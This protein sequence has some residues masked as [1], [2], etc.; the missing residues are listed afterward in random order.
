MGGL[1][2]ELKAR[3]KKSTDATT[4][5]AGGVEENVSVRSHCSHRMKA[6]GV[7]AEAVRGSRCRKHMPKAPA[8]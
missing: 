7:E 3:A 4:A 6:D 2:G 5:E 8:Q 1:K